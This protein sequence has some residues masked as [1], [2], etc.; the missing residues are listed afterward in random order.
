MVAVRLGKTPVGRVEA[1]YLGRK[2]GSLELFDMH[3]IDYDE[4]AA[5]H[6]DDWALLDD[7]KMP[8]G[9]AAPK[10]IDKRDY[11]VFPTPESLKSNG[12]PVLD[13]S[14]TMNQVKRKI[15]TGAA[16]AP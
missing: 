7:Y 15:R 16:G 2:D 8:S 9:P 6:P 4:A 1:Y 14:L 10:I 5:A 11:P 3:Y 13:A 12:P